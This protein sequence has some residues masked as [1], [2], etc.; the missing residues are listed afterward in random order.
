MEISQEHSLKSLAENYKTDRQKT[1][2]RFLT[3]GSVDDGKSTLI[4]RLLYETGAIF[5]NELNNLTLD[6]K[7]YGTTGTELDYSL[8]VDGLSSEREQ[9]I[10]I[11][12]AYR[13][14]S[15]PKRKFIVAD[16]PGHEQYTRNMATG[17]SGSDCAI[18]MIDARKGVLTQTKR[19]SFIVSTMAIKKIIVAINKIDLIDYEQAKI[20]QIEYD[21]LDFAEKLNFTEI[22]IIPL[23]ALQGDNIT[24]HSN[25]T[26][27]YKGPVL[28]DKLETI[29]VEMRENISNQP[30][31]FPV[32]WVNRPNLNF[33]GY[34]GTITSG[35]VKIG[36]KV[37]ILPSGK[38]SY[39]D[40]I[41][42]FDGEHESAQQGQAITLTLKDEIDIS[43]GNV[44]CT[45]DEPCFV[46]QQFQTTII[47]LCDKPMILSRQYVFKLATETALAT[48]VKIKQ[49][50]DIN[51]LTSRNVNKL[52]LNDC[53]VVELNLTKDIAYQEYTQSR[54]LGGFILVDRE[55]NDTV[56]CGTIDFALRRNG[57]IYKQKFSVDRVA[58][59]KLKGHKSSII[60]L[61][62][63]SGSG[64]STIA[65]KVEQK[66]HEIGVHSFILDGDNIRHGLNNDLGFTETA[67]AENIRR[68][69]EVAKLLLQAGIVTIVSFISPFRAD[70]QMAME[71][72][73]EIDFNEIHIDVPLAVAERRDVKGLYKK[74]RAGEVK[75]FTGIDSP[76][77]PPLFPSLKIDTMNVSP[78]QAA[79]K[80]IALLKKKN[81]IL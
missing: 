11:D 79:D 65:N 37:R 39:I 2:L 72:I 57:N 70:R 52:Q 9:G 19:H 67:R 43:R 76:Y 40:K 71:L 8:L 69:A 7:K 3:C 54:T 16:T 61:T 23:S 48:P 13:F 78:E 38:E 73:G 68:V 47:W 21:F 34:A 5:D 35:N 27:W 46:A 6:S 45:S 1:I 17:A 15:T 49:V 28:L 53:A 81:V 77:E 4:G 26:P 75:N 25:R 22:S 74:A 41:I 31:R 80:I 60:W 42:T 18:I 10:T 12:V 36:Q 14:F 63:L 55:T 59:A 20:A 56:A 29:D 24:K 44:I 50:I 66:L 58:Q 32:Q 64:K 30:L 62:G 33:R 51:S